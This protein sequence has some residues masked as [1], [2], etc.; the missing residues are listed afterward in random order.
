MPQ[1]WM[2]KGYLI[3]AVEE[4]GVEAFRDQVA[5]LQT[6]G[7]EIDLFDQQ[8]RIVETIVGTFYASVESAPIVLNDQGVPEF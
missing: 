1:K 2:V 4:G 8:G 3:M 5:S 6:S 7:V